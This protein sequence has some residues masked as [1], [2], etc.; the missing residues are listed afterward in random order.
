VSAGRNFWNSLTLKS[1]DFPVAKFRDRFTICGTGVVFDSQFVEP[2]CSDTARLSTEIESAHPR[3]WAI[4]PHR[5][6][7]LSKLPESL[8]G[9]RFRDATAALGIGSTRFATTSDHQV[10]R[11]NPFEP[12]KHGLPCSAV[13]EISAPFVP[14]IVNRNPEIMLIRTAQRAESHK[15]RLSDISSDEARTTAPVDYL[16]SMDSV[17][18]KHNGFLRP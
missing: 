10:S 5:A 3:D 6:K 11:E 9:D 16:S 7:I 17:S 18:L 14:Q 1:N 2:D 4:A 13:R 12:A 8:T 15:F